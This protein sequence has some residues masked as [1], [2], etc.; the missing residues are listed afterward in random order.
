MQ[1]VVV[2]LA[3]CILWRDFCC[4]YYAFSV[5]MVEI[6]PRSA[7]RTRPMCKDLLRPSASRS[8]YQ[9]AFRLAKFKSVIS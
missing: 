5:V 2:A 4:F 9:G 8:S 3:I 6:G 1:S 7:L